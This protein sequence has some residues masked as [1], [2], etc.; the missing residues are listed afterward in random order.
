MNLFNHFYLCWNSPAGIHKRLKIHH[1]SQQRFFCRINYSQRIPLSLCEIH[2]TKTFQKPHGSCSLLELTLSILDD[3]LSCENSTFPQFVFL[4]FLENRVFFSIHRSIQNTIIFIIMRGASNG[5][6]DCEI[7][8]N[9]ED[10]G[11]KG[12]RKPKPQQQQEMTK[13][14]KRTLKRREA[15]KKNQPQKQK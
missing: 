1:S 11:G 4:H 15:K 2:R 6:K 9:T 12:E 7:S 8:M 13:K 10:E 3:D 5:I 14:K